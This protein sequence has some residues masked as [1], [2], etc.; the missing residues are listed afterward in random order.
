VHWSPLLDA[1]LVT[2]YQE[3]TGGLRDP[4]LRSDRVS[5]NARAVPGTARPKYAS[6]LNHVSNWLGFTDPPKHT[7]MREVAR[8]VVNPAVAAKSRPMI[9]ASVRE[10]VAG[11]HQRDDFDLVE[12]LALRLPLTVVCRLLGV[13][14]ENVTDFHQWATEVGAF[15]GHVDPTWDA[16]AQ[17]VIE[18]AN[19]GWLKLEA[20]FGRLVV[21]KRQDPGDD[22]LSELVRAFDAGAISEDELIGLCVFILAAGHTTTR[23]LLGN[24]LYLLLARPEETEKL[25]GQP[26]NVA[27]AVEEVLRF[28]SPIPMASR[29][30][31]DTVTL[32]EKTLGPGSTV[33]LHLGAANRD[34][35]KFPD[36]G[37]FD[38]LRKQ[39]RQIAFGYGAHFC[40]GAP[41]AREQGAAVLEALL[42]DLPRLRLKS[43]VP[44]WFTGNMSLRTLTKLEVSWST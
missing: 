2:S 32:G 19:E 35:D 21:Q 31:G 36:A 20:L 4:G 14:D 17:S 15:A 18:Q 6:L 34:P 3:V 23:D 37:T 43:Q 30:A 22:I 12:D 28:E 7:Q 11:L 38:V 5:I 25:L 41:L 10:I 44:A 42:P 13:P 29:L 27:S 16:S 39:N 40:L 26:A 8:K 1:W 33:I 24:G 9:E